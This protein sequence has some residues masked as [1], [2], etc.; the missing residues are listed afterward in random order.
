MNYNL[1][2]TDELQGTLV[3]TKVIQ[4][5]QKRVTTQSQMDQKEVEDDW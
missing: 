1:K 4:E 2:K 3:N 5:I